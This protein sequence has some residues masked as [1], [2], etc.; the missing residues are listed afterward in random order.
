MA[1]EI[2]RGITLCKGYVDNVM[3]IDIVNG[4]GWLSLC[5]NSLEK[6]MNP[7]LLTVGK[8]NRA[9]WFPL[10]WL[11]ENNSEFKT[12]ESNGKSKYYLC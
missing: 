8:N 4:I 9:E 5:D 1:Q 6:Y 11:K 2:L 12:G 10:L 3:V 7:S